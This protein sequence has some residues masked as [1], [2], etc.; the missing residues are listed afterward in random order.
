MLLGEKLG[1][2]AGRERGRRLGRQVAG[3]RSSGRLFL[4]S[5]ERSSFLL[6]G[7]WQRQRGAAC[8]KNAFFF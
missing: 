6:L 1:A 5:F 8:P 3:R 7:F 4:S 2:A